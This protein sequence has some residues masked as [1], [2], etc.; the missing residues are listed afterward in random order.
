MNRRYRNRMKIRLT[1]VARVQA[2]RLRQRGIADPGNQVA[3]PKS[4]DGSSDD[5]SL[6]FPRS[7]CAAYHGC[8]CTV[9]R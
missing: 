7:A 5:A 3:D 4:S 6:L 1:R 8:A 9:T 2:N